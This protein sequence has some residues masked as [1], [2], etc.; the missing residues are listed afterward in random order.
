[1]VT[2][3]KSTR[4]KFLFECLN[5]ADERRSLLSYLRCRNPELSSG[6]LSTT[7]VL[8]RFLTVCGRRATHQMR[9]C[10]TL[11]GKSDTTMINH[12]IRD[13]STF[14]PALALILTHIHTY[15]LAPRPIANDAPSPTIIRAAPSWRR[16][17]ARV[18]TGL[19]G[20]ATMN[21]K[22]SSSMSSSVAR[23]RFS[24]TSQIFLF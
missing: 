10:N 24:I 13:C 14:P 19:A 5:N 3:R 16:S 15:A 21:H 12:L 2:N 18:S 22:E 6:L 1:M 8:I 9:V 20:P 23:A 4:R 17:P 7:K 11:R